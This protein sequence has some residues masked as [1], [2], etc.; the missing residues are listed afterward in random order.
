LRRGGCRLGEARLRRC[1]RAR[2]RL[3]NG[4]PFLQELCQ[5]AAIERLGDVIVHAGREAALAI[6]GHRVRGHRDDRKM[7]RAG[8]AL[9]RAP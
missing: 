8:R 1:G 2:P 4:E 3:R 7:S 6:A 9:A 5:R